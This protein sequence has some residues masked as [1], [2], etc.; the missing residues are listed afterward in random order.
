MVAPRKYPEELRERSLQPHSCPLRPAGGLVGGGRH[1]G[2]QG[3][4]GG[5]RGG[6]E[7]LGA[8]G[9]A[10]DAGRPGAPPAAPARTGGQRVRPGEQADGVEGIGLGG[11]AVGVGVV[12]SERQQAGADVTNPVRCRRAV[13]TL[14]GRRG[15]AQGEGRAATATA[16]A[17]GAD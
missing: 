15:R 14:A 5:V 3:S 8:G 17:A 7:Q 10:A 6:V 16:L 4:T 13:G 11:Q 9:A 12:R 1:G 2:Q